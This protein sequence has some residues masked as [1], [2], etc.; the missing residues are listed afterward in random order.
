MGTQSSQHSFAESDINADVA[1]EAT[2]DSTDV[3]RP[4]VVVVVRAASTVGSAAAL[5][6]AKRGGELV[7][8]DR[9]GEALAETIAACREAGGTALGVPMDVADPVAVEKLAKRA[10]GYFGHVDVWVNAAGLAAEKPFDDAFL[11]E[12]GRL[13]ELNLYPG[14]RDFPADGASNVRAS[15]IGDGLRAVRGNATAAAMVLATV[16]LGLGLWLNSSRR[17]R[18]RRQ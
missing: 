11:Q 13:L 1:A 15:R 5:E 7:L 10:V 2:S 8:A 17:R 9:N 12:N 14:S 4:W 6:F 18:R 3:V 16:G